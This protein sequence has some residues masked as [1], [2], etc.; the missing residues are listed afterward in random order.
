MKYTNAHMHRYW[1]ACTDATMYTHPDCA[2][3]HTSVET[4]HTHQ[5]NHRQHMCHIAHVYA[6]VDHIADVLMPVE[7]P[8]TIFAAR[9]VGLW[10]KL[11]VIP[12]HLYNTHVCK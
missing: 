6:R 8:I 1:F 9:L 3:E 7:T 4:M 11:H 12:T 2:Q 10:M 5:Q